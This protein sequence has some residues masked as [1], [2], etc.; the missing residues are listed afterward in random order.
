MNGIGPIVRGPRLPHLGLRL[1]VGRLLLIVFLLMIIVL[2]VRG[3]ASGGIWS[4]ELR[5]KRFDV[6]RRM[7][8]SFKLS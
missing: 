8:L 6:M 5:T 1:R 7:L 2:V 3:K 4:R